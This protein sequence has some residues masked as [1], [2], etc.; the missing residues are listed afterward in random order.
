MDG[1][2][3]YWNRGGGEIRGSIYGN[4]SQRMHC[5][6]R[7]GGANFSCRTRT[8]RRFDVHSK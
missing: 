6:M 2:L 3:L 8:R 7:R 5:Q 1:K 4:C